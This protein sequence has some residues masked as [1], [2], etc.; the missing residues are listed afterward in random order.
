MGTIDTGAAP[1]TLT[2]T[3][4]DGSTVTLT[5]Y[6]SILTDGGSTATTFIQAKATATDGSS[7]GSTT[8]EPGAETG[9]GT[10]M[11]TAETGE[12]TTKHHETDIATA[13]GRTAAQQFTVL[14]TTV[15]ASGETTTMSGYWSEY[16]DGTAP[17]SSFL[18]AKK[19]M[20]RTALPGP[21]SV[22]RGRARRRHK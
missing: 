17:T 15:L 7:G 1:K 20:R 3:G 16:T 8:A 12:G 10:G 14:V 21:T 2:T 6:D 11:G 13:D 19:R 22:P 5:G 18:T 4:S 9:T